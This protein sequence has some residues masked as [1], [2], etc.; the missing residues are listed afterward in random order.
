[1]DVKKLTTAAILSAAF[2]VS[3][4]IFIGIGLGYLGYIDFVVPVFIAI[5]CLKCDFKYSVLASV[6]CLVLVMLFIGNIAYVVTMVQ[7]MILGILIGTIVK[8][9]SSM[10]DDWFHCSMI[11]AFLIILM[12]INFSSLTG[13]SI[14]KESEE[15]IR[16]LPTTYDYMKDVI[17]YM[18][19]ATLP[20]GTVL[21]CYVLTLIIGKKFKIL[22]SEALIKAK[23]LCNYKK[24]S[25][26]ISCSR[27][28]IYACGIWV[29]VA[30][31]LNRISF[32]DGHTYLKI[33]INTNSYIAMFF[34]IQDSLGMI[35]KYVFFKTKSRSKLLIMQVLMIFALM[36][37][38]K[39]TMIAMFI[40][41]I[42]ID[43]N[44]KIKYRDNILMNK[45]ADNL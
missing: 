43:K 9:K 31:L 33:I 19:V 13:Y 1:M 5:I 45:I 17:L 26:L 2:V 24:Y 30:C 20:L 14:L 8:R 15:Y 37:F 22:K 35:N 34:I 44:Y 42:F 21:L 4:L 6:T 11:A 40:I 10:F 3:S 12:D 39:I 27:N 7:S 25:S 32:F 18:S 36:N 38:F 28:T 41:D 29:I 23:I 16:Y